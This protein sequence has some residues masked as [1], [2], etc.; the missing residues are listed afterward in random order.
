MRLAFISDLHG[1]LAALDAVLAD[2]QQRQVD[3]LVCL[4]DVAT[5]GPQPCAVLARLQQS[6]C[7][8]VLGNHD[9]FLLNPALLGEYTQEPW[10]IQAVKWC[11]AQ[12]SPAEV[13]YIRSF[14]P[15][16]RLPVSAHTSLLCFHGAPR[17][18]TIGLLAETPAEEIEAMLAGHQAA[19][20]IS[21][22][23]HEPMLRLWKG[24]L[25]INA[26]S[27]GQAFARRPGVTPP[28]LLPYA[29]YALVSWEAGGLEVA[30]R[31]VP[32][33]LRT[34]RQA[35]L[36]S[37][38]PWASDW[39]SWWDELAFNISPKSDTVVPVPEAWQTGKE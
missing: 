31:H 36:A 18:N 21:G 6:G 39:I 17:S 34:L 28:R 26:G 11:Q 38:W 35:A 8:C 23:T 2:I 15:L 29:Q 24:R 19:I 3:E 16:L 14:Q 33:D 1:N 37:P 25:L 32:L 12:L 27:V 22:H 4:G 30:L 10:V 20:F 5:L 9:A 13:E 7:A